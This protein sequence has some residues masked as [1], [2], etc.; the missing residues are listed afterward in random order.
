MPEQV[1]WGPITL[2]LDNE[3]FRRGFFEAR[4]W[5]FEDIYG[6]DGRLPEEPGRAV[7]VSSEEVLRLIVMPDAQGCYHL[8]LTGEEHLPEYLGYLGA[9]L[10]HTE[11][12]H[13]R[14]QQAQVE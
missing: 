2:M 10:A 9:P 8:D 14:H 1:A 5:Y 12:E 7:Q 11:A 6:Q 13:Y 3:D 4:R